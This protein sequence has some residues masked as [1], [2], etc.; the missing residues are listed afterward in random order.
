MRVGH[1]HGKIKTPHPASNDCNR[2]LYLI[3]GRNPG[4][5]VTAVDANHSETRMNQKIP[6][7]AVGG[8]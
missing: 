6:Y 3:F 2:W 4:T 7:A 1:A 5:Y 8:T